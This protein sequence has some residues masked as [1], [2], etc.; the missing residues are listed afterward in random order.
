MEG[1]DS[2]SLEYIESYLP[3]GKMGPKDSKRFARDVNGTSVDSLAIS[4]IRHE[5][6]QT[7]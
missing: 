5:T 6:V 4:V 7:A 3:N 2:C 1:R